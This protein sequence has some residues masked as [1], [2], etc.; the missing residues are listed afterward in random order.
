MAEK[1]DPK[2]S[3]SVGAQL[4]GEPRIVPNAP[5]PTVAQALANAKA[6]VQAAK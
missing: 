6:Q 1:K 2:I 3:S 5:V 4:Q